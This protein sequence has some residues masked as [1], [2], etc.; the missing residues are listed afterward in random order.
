MSKPTRIAGCGNA[1][2]HTFV[3][4]LKGNDVRLVR[5]NVSRELFARKGFFIE[6]NLRVI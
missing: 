1:E 2:R 4:A 5:H 3:K 6:D